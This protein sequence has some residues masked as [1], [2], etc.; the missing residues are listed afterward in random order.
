VILEIATPAANSAGYLGRGVT[1]AGVQRSYARFIEGQL[2]G[3]E[4]SLGKSTAMDEVLSQ[5]EQVFNDSAGLGL[6]ES[7]QAFFDSWESLA[8]DP[9]DT[10]QRTV[11]L[12]DAESLVSTAKQMEKDLLETIGEINDEIA[13]IADHVKRSPARSPPSTSRSRRSRRGTRAR[14]PTT[15]WTAGAAC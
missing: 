3:Q 1:I 15:C 12:S 7:L 10:A 4:Q 5:V 9:D 11:L 13:D 14:R 6:S 2:L 8:S